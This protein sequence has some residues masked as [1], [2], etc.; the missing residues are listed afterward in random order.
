MAIGVFV[1]V[2][3]LGRFVG[4]FTVALD[5]GDVKLSLSE[6]SSFESP[7][8]YIKLKSIPGFGS[9]TF[10]D[11][12]DDE[13]L[14]NEENTYSKW[15][16]KGD[17]GETLKFFKYTFFVKNNGMAPAS[18][19]LKVNL[20][21]NTPSTD[22]RYLDSILRVIVYHNNVNSDTHE[23][24]IYAKKSDVANP[25]Y[26]YEDGEVTFK[27]YISFRDPEKAEDY[28]YTFPGFAN[29]FESD[30]VVA[31]IPQINLESDETIRYTIVAW[32]EGEDKQATGPAPENATLKLGVTIN[33]YE[34]Q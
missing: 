19:D 32:L 23:R 8:S 9:I 20:T 11:L 34:N 14:D 22:N 17:D 27:E 31:K 10:T 5:M 1:L 3:F 7:T 28:G 12:P 29:V 24:S 33:A 13:E 16:I 18:Y 15:I 6:K 26:G 25:T 30:T 21:R 4:T 2:A